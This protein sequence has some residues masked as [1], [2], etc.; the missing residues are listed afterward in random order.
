MVV[1]ERDI[2]VTSDDSASA[3]RISCRTATRRTV[4]GGKW[5]SNLHP[6]VKPQEF[7]RSVCPFLTFHTTPATRS[8]SGPTTL[9]A[10]ARKV[11]VSS[12]LQIRV[13]IFCLMPVSLASVPHDTVFCLLLFLFG[14][15]A[16]EGGGAD[17]DDEL[18]LNV[19]RCHLTY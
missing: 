15:G 6:K 8:L 12:S 13:R 7:T 17:D 9:T 16:G 11:I 14:R 5:T 2:P 19:L 18:M 3:R 4:T 1:V 10:G